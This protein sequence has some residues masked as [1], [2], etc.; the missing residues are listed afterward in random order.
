MS[1]RICLPLSCISAFLCVSFILR[2]QWVAPNDVRLLISA[3]LAERDCPH[4]SPRSRTQRPGNL[5]W[6]YI[7]PLKGGWGKDGCP[8]EN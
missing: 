7:I 4:E 1:S 5:G 3:A 6:A 2:F 8:V